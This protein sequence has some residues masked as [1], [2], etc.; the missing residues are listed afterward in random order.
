[1]SGEWT[2]VLKNLP[3]REPQMWVLDVAAD[4]I[5]DMT[6]ATADFF[7]NHDP[8]SDMRTLSKKIHTDTALFVVKT[9]QATTLL[10][11]MKYSGAWHKRTRTTS[12]V[13]GSL[14]L[15][16]SLDITEFDP[17]S[18][19]LARINLDSQRLEM[20]SGSS[21]SFLEFAVLHMLLKGLKYKRIAEL[22]SVTTKTVEYRIS[23]LKNAL[24]AESTEEM[25]L[26]VYYSG[27]IYLG[28]IEIDLEN[29]AQTE[30]ELYKK[31]LG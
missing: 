21:I 22:L 7:A 3:A 11:W 31:V 26:K 5:I 30:L 13:D 23:R 27:L 9:K 25:M 4:T 15:I 2:P 19:W 10:E 1:M 29:P 14:V 8:A 12:H 17:R 28:L 18:E 24:D 6:P 16:H 20:E